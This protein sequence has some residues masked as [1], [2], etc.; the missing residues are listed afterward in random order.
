MTM[1]Q[2]QSLFRPLQAVAALLLAA[3]MILFIPHMIWPENFVPSDVLQPVAVTWSLLSFS[4]VLAV[5]WPSGTEELKAA[6]N[7]RRYKKACSAFLLLVIGP[8]FFGFCMGLWFI[9]GPVS[10]HLHRVSNSAILQTTI[11]RVQYADDFGPRSCRN[12]AVLV[13]D[14]FLW[15]RRVCKLLPGDMEALRKGGAIAVF[16]TVS[17]FGVLVKESNIKDVDAAPI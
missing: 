7:E 14:R 13:G 15:P 2:L 10:Y 9:A 5:I 16:G 4:A 8:V 6:F 1:H 11:H 3:Q 12:R 17:N